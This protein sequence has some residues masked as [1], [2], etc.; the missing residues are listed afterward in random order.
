MSTILRQAIAF[1]PLLVV[2]CGTRIDFIPMNTAPRAMSARTPESVQV[3]ATAPPDRPYVEVGSIEAQQE[4][5]LSLDNNP[6]VMQKLRQY[7]AE[8]GCDG[9]VVNGTNNA[10]VGASPT[11]TAG[12]DP[13]RLSSRLHRLQGPATRRPPQSSVTE[14]IP[15]LRRFAPGCA[16]SE[17][18]TRP[19]SATGRP[20]LSGERA[21]GEPR[22][23]RHGSGAVVAEAFEADR[24]FFVGR[25]PLAHVRAV[26]PRNRQLLRGNKASATAS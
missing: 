6:E 3:F 22:C 4:S 25:S 2:G 20:P 21:R 16:R 13:A 5:A 8:H 14:R 17:I 23:L 26:A 10:V 7:A 18:M 1:L 11:A 12:T 9:I 24:F 19:V 15:R